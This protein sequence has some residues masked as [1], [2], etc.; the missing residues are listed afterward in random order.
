MDKKLYKLMNWPL[1]EEIVYSE[2][3]DPHRI[4]GKHKAGS[5]TLVQAFFPGAQEVYLHWVTTEKEKETGK[6][7]DYAY[8]AKMEQADEVGFFAV[9]A[10]AKNM[11]SYRFK[12]MPVFSNHVQRVFD[13]FVIIRF[14]KIFRPCDSFGN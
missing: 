4:L 7:I 12:V 10:P 11:T 14:R 6:T 2:S 5:Q 1:I 8:D 3:A 9:L 13:F